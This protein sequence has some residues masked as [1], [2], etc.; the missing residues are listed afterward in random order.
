MT[1]AQAERL[2]G[3]ENVTWDLSVYYNGIDDPKIESDQKELHALAD[4]FAARYRGKLAS[5]S[6]AQFV[7]AYADLE[8]LYELMN[9]IGTYASLNYSVYSTDQ[10]WGAFMQKMMEAQSVLAQKMV[11]FELEWNAL[12]DDKADA[13]LNDPILAPI[14]YYMQSER[15]FKPYKLSEIEEQLMIE[16]DVTGA[17]AWTRLFDQIMASIEVEFEGQKLNMPRVLSK[18]HDEDRDVRQKAAD[19]ITGALRERQMELSYI[20]NVLAADKAADDKR[21]S[22]PS[23]I[24]SR[25]LS[26]SA[27]DSVVEALIEAVTS[28]YELVARH[29]K[30]KRALL[31]HDELYDYDRY[32]PLALKESDNFYTWEEARETVLAAYGTFSNDIRDLAAKFFDENWIHAPVL[33]GKRGGAYAT[34]G[35]HGTHPWVFTNYN[36]KATD[37]MTL[38]H[39][40]GHG[41]HMYLAARKQN[42]FGMYTPLT[43]AEMASTFGEMLVFSDLM[44]KESDQEVQLAMITEKI[45][46]SFA[47]IFRQVSMNRFEDAMHTA[48]RE[49][50]ELSVER[51]SEIWLSTQK[52]MFGDSV[53]MREDYGLWWSY[54]PHFLHTPGYVYAYAFGELLVL[55]LYNLY[56]SEGEAFVPKYIELLSAG[57][58]DDPDKL[59]AK[60]GVNLNDPAFWNQGIEALKDLI[61]REEALAK[62]LYPDKF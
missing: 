35:S 7:E 48:R 15:R 34:Y 49:E 50:G 9:R 45:E 14:R 58:S 28:N 13:I 5:M 6:A 39:E 57:G 40:L 11:F 46:D 3:A 26:N 29:Y 62:S 21:R 44:K 16:K 54:I 61:D 30:I 52:E 22:Y 38:A 23:W 31:G 2:T 55:A 60:V 17:S 41:T 8:K 19:A 37:I 59:L 53:T 36:G 20:F 4:A 27:P 25:N 56:Q 47:T 12:E 42:T 24:T 10:K 18:L 51:L 43:T 32:A 1:E 33:P